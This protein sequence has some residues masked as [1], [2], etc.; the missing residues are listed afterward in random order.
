[1]HRLHD[2]YC[3]KEIAFLC[4]KCIDLANKHLDKMKQLTYKWHERILKMFLERQ[5]ESYATRYKDL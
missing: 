4:D 1:M 3:T 2:Q 5:K